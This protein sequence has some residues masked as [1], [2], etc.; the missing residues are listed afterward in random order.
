M[1]SM[2]DCTNEPADAMSSALKALDSIYSST[3]EED[4]G[5]ITVTLS[6]SAKLH[7]RPFTIA[8]EEE[9]IGK[10]RVLFGCK[11]I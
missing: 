10:K 1:K 4:N 3:T 8:E 2:L 9:L 6:F 7:I 11:P 5:E